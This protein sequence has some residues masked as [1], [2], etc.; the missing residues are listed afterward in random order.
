MPA[1]AWHAIIMRSGQVCRDSMRASSQLSLLQA[2]LGG[3]ERRAPTGLRPA[4]MQRAHV[5][6]ALCNIACLFLASIGT[7]TDAAVMTCYHIG[8]S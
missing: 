7:Q 2:R 6:C 5:Y 1:H 3:C 4:L 8:L